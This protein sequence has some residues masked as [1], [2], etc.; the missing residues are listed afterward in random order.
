MSRIYVL[1]CRYVA[2]CL[3]GRN[4]DRGRRWIAEI[5]DLPGALAYGA[6]EKEA[7]ATAQAIALRVLAD[8]IE[9]K[10]EPAETV[11]VSI[12]AD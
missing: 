4:G 5:P 3:Q 11:T 7:I 2:H 8:Q 10:K 1:G 12:E 6:T 9:N